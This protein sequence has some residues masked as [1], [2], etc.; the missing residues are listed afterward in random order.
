MSFTYLASPFSDPD[1]LVR[2]RRYRAA[3]WAVGHYTRSRIVVYSPIV[4]YHPPHAERKFPGSFDFWQYFNYN[5]IDAASGLWVLCIPGWEESKGVQSEITY[6]TK[7]NLP[8]K[9]ITHDS[10]LWPEGL[11]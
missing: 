9:C 1:P 6:A 5:M 4:H 8:V 3:I 2:D 7:V 10:A 11:E